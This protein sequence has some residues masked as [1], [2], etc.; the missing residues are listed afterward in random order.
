MSKTTLGFIYIGMLYLLVGIILGALFIIVPDSGRLRFVHVH[1][2]LVGFVIFLIFG[3]GYHIL[4]RFRGRPLHSEG[5]AW[6]QFWV[7]NIGLVGLVTFNVLVAYGAIRD[8]K[9]AMALF[10]SL[11]VVSVFLFIY[12]MARTLLPPVP[13]PAARPAS[14]K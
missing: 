12:N 9:T 14:A 4:P 3:I 1:L 6:F 5:L 8:G 10:G 2:N 13:K 11:L 7:A